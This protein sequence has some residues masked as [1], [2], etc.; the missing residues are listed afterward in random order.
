[1]PQRKKTMMMGESVKTAPPQPTEELLTVHE[2]A[3]CLRVDDV[4]VRRWMSNGALDAV[5]LPRLG[6]RRSYRVKKMTVEKLLGN[7][8]LASHSAPG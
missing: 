6:K 1:M 4:T 5:V 8:M 7:P 3:L 2:V